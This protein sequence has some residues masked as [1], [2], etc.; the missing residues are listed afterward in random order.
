[1]VRGLAIANITLTHLLRTR[2]LLTDARNPQDDFQTRLRAIQ[3]QL[4]RVEHWED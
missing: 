3:R 4:R 1:M 2:K